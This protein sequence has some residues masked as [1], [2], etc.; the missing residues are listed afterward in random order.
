MQ[1]CSNVGSQNREQNDTENHLQ[2]RT[3]WGMI[4]GRFLT[5]VGSLLGAQGDPTH[6][7][8][9]PRIASAAVL[10]PKTTPKIILQLRVGC[11]GC[12][13][14]RPQGTQRRN[15]RWR[16]RAAHLDNSFFH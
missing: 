7:L 15:A 3:I 10:P 1:T 13:P 16:N 4:S 11:A 8:V 5:N 14:W 9:A 12:R 2:I 6:Q